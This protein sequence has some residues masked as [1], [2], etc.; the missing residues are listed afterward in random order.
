MSKK[1]LFERKRFCKY[2]HD[3]HIVGRTN[4]RAGSHCKECRRVQ[5]RQRRV[6][7]PAWNQLRLQRRTAQ[8]HGMTLEQLK[9]AIK[10]R[11]GCCDICVLVGDLRPKKKLCQDHDKITGQNRGMLCDRHNFGI[12]QFHH[13]P[14]ELMA[15]C[16]YMRKYGQ[17]K[18]V[19]T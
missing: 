4:E 18:L 3:T 6:A 5:G 16:Q 2:G 19:G 8:R 11:K 9:A 7:N 14:E 12:G 13:S 15:A 1:K 17:L 10:L